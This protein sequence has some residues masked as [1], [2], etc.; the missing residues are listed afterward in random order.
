MSLFNVLELE[1]L[2]GRNHPSPTRL[3]QNSSGDCGSDCSSLANTVQTNSLNLN[4]SKQNDASRFYPSPDLEGF[5]YESCGP[6]SDRDWIIELLNSAGQTSNS[7]SIGSYDDQIFK[8]ESIERHI[9]SPCSLDGEAS[10]SPHNSLS[11][12]DATSSI[13]S[14]LPTRDILSTQASSRIFI[15]RSFTPSSFDEHL[16]DIDSDAMTFLSPYRTPETLQYDITGDLPY[17]PK[18]V[19]EEEPHCPEH[20]VEDCDH[21][22]TSEPYHPENVLGDELCYLKRPDATVSSND[23]YFVG[24]LVRSDDR[25]TSHDDYIS[26]SRTKDNRIQTPLYDYM[27]PTPSLDNGIT[28]PSSVYHLATPAACYGHIQHNPSI[29]PPFMSW[30]RSVESMAMEFE[31]TLSPV[32]APLDL[33]VFEDGAFRIQTPGY[34][35]MD[36]DDNDEYFYLNDF[37]RSS[38]PGYLPVDINTLNSNLDPDEDRWITNSIEYDYECSHSS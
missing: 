28:P 13:L 18:D 4:S 1:G 33:N 8:Y 31:A 12:Y 38:S 3:L 9:P 15:S 32:I 14:P 25:A 20:L 23:E 11:A 2:N 37:S 30:Y 22:L 26:A 16:S 35:P 7:T 6:E 29:R 19:L 36:D 17:Y 21:D 27:V 5:A 34:D 10:R 24:H